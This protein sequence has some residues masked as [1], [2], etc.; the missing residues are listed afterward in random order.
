[1]EHGWRS[2]S[3]LLQLLQ[4]PNSWGGG[5]ISARLWWGG[6]LLCQEE[7]LSQIG[8]QPDFSTPDFRFFS[9]PPPLQ[10][11]QNISPHHHLFSGFRDLSLLLAVCC[12]LQPILFFFGGGGLAGKDARPESGE[13]KEIKTYPKVFARILEPFPSR[14]KPPAGSPIPRLGETSH[15]SLTTPFGIRRRHW[16]RQL[17]SK[18]A[19]GRI[20]GG[21]GKH[22][23]R[24]PGWR[25][26]GCSEEFASSGLQV[27][28]PQGSCGL[29]VCV[30]GERGVARVFPW[31]ALQVALLAPRTPLVFL[32]FSARARWCEI[33]ARF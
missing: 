18:A 24:T 22:H 30:F 16:R 14:S 29:G 17:D 4:R 2:T 13:E 3:L 31:S 5:R 9:P 6:P 19:S 33:A 10:T 1:M 27:A 11:K 32:S 12:L 21:L 8:I 15:P 26:P 28:S 7:T 25:C 23:L 20:E